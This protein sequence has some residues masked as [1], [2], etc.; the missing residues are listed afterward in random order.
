MAIR[1]YQVGNADD[2]AKQLAAVLE[3]PELE[4]EMAERNFAA[5]LEMTITNVVGNYLRWFELHRCKRLL[6]EFKEP[7]KPQL[8]LDALRERSPV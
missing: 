3:S 8:R 1:F 5:G 4:R 6:R 2:L 7:F